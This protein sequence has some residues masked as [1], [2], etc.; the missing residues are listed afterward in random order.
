MKTDIKHSL[1]AATVILSLGVFSG[2]SDSAS[3]TASNSSGVVTTGGEAISQLETNTEITGTRLPTCADAELSTVASTMTADDHVLKANISR[4]GAEIY[5]QPSYERSNAHNILRKLDVTVAPTTADGNVSDVA[6]T[7]Y[8][9]PI[10]VAYAEQVIGDYA[11]NDG[12]ADIGDPYHID[13]IFVSTSLDGGKTWKK[14]NVSNTADKS[15]IN[16]TWDTQYADN[17]AYSAGNVAYPGH[18]HKPSMQ[19][20]GNNIL[21]SWND[22]YC[23][24]GNPLEL[25][26]V[27]PDADKIVYPDDLWK[28]NGK[29]G[30][31]NYDL[32]CDIPD[33][34]NTKAIDE[35]NCAPNGNE[36]Y[37]VPFSCVW[38]ARATFD[39]AGGENGE[40]VFTWHQ[41]EQLTAAVRDSN[42]IWIAEAPGVGF[43]MSWQED[44]EGLREGKGAGPGDGWSG[45]TTNHG[46]DIW[47]SYLN[48]DDFNLTVDVE[49]E[50]AEEDTL[51]KP[52]SLVNLSYPVRIS[53]NESCNNEDQKFYCQQLAGV[54][55]NTFKPEVECTEWID[56][57]SDQGKPKCQT[58]VLDPLWLNDD[59]NNLTT[60]ILDGDTGASRPAIAIM[61]TGVEGEAVVVLAYEETKGLNETDPGVPDQDKTNETDIDS[62]DIAVEGKIAL[63]ESFPFANP[64]TLSPGHI[65]NPRVETSDE[66]KEQYPDAPETIYE[67][68]RR[69]VLITQVDRCVAEGTEFNFGVM[70]KMGVETRGGASDMFVRLNRGF[71]ADTFVNAD[72]N[73]FG[74]GQS[75]IP[76]L[77]AMDA[78]EVP[79]EDG[80]VDVNE[81]TWTIDNMSS[82]SYDNVYENTFSPRG[83][84]RQSDMYF[85]YEYTPNYAKGEQGNMPN[86]FWIIRYTQ[87]EGDA[88][89]VWHAPQNLSN[90]LGYKIS[91]LDPRFIPTAMAVNGTDL[92]SDKSNPEVMFLTYGTFNMETGEEED[93]F[94]TRST[95]KGKDWLKVEIPVLDENDQ[96]LTQN[97]KISALQDVQEKEIQSIATP[98]GTMLYNVWLQEE[99]PEHYAT[100]DTPEHFK[101]L[102]SWI[103][104]VDFNNTIEE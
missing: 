7:E 53:D 97:P 62:T 19:V 6:T 29:Q 55:E 79:A 61:K 77:S 33:D 26:P 72:E 52:K 66:Y 15:S 30:S 22:K 67:N 10:V 76:N 88:G 4:E 73:I 24:S 23:P 58:N 75:G 103:G 68:A 64:V 43:A 85:G 46:A 59:E 16:V 38:T 21:V 37:E 47:Y 17:N 86:N 78:V 60:V 91:T 39:P 28:V 94:Y 101:G 14:I 48:W 36:V 51:V 74:N 102:D 42:K 82:N 83:F 56:A 84:L 31:I 92:E 80:S 104:I 5:P 54:I 50:V 11:M 96:N 40:G 32:K 12:S 98:D 3:N 99:L 71:T 13:D 45:A 1:I 41:A 49:E 18:S 9:H 57:N 70:Y 90:V 27:D 69:V 44:P 2:C 87:D 20:S 89:R 63:F 25:E 8:V 93:V 95:N 65:V 35:S 34:P 100:G 81:S